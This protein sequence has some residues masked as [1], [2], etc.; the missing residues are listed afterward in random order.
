MARRRSGAARSLLGYGGVILV[1]LLA[2]TL[3]VFSFLRSLPDSSGGGFR[4]HDAGGAS[5][6][7]RTAARP[8]PRLHEQLDSGGAGGAA[9]TGQ[10]AEPDAGE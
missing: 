3:V 1:V 4:K 10:Q 7:S 5:G 9:V 6:A 8:G 2:P